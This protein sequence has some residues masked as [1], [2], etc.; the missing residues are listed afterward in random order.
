MS[1]AGAPV[2]LTLNVL[3]SVPNPTLGGQ[4]FA[5]VQLQNSSVFVIQVVADGLQYTIQPFTAQTVPLSSTGNPITILP[6]QNP[7]GSTVGGSTLTPVWL[8]PGEAP[9]MQDGPLTAAAIVAAITGSISSQGVVDTLASGVAVGGQISL[10]IPAGSV[11]HSYATLIV[12]FTGGTYPNVGTTVAAAVANGGQ[13]GFVIQ[14]ENTGGA[15]AIIPFG[16]VPGVGFTIT[17]GPALP[18]GIVATVLGLTQGIAVRVA[19]QPGYP[20]GVE[21]MGGTA[22]ITGAVALNGGSVALLAAPATGYWYRLHRFIC[23]NIAAASATSYLLDGAGNYLAAVGPGHPADDLGGQI[24]SLAVSAINQTGG[25]ASFT[26]TYDRVTP[27]N[28]P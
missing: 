28:P 8:L 21:P 22:V 25:A 14:G 27:V 3:A 24:T 23:P 9:P 13:V 18:A 7:G 5:A 19:P 10:A 12:V 20:V 2:T 26:L 11:Q 4:D 6:T 1:A 16:N 15:W 17:F